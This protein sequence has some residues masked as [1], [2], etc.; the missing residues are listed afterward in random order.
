MTPGEVAGVVAS[1]AALL[2]AGGWIAN[3]G[4]NQIQ[5]RKLEA[6]TAKAEMELGTARGNNAKTIF[7]TAG[8]LVENLRL[9]VARQSLRLKEMEDRD[10]R[11]RR[12]EDTCQEQL[13]EAKEALGKAL[14]R[15]EVLEARAVKRDAGSD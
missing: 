14:A 6:E 8:E 3:L 9:E 7:F 11:R 4:L 1:F 15:I 5:R 13:D 2:G 10:E 12:Q